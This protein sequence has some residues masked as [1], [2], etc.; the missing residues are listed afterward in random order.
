MQV[1]V[2]HVFHLLARAHS[3]HEILECAK[4]PP[5]LIQ[6]TGYRKGAWH[7]HPGSIPGIRSVGSID[8]TLRVLHVT[9]PTHNEPP[10]I[11]LNTC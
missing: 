3:R 8:V 11:F 1:V 9:C 4:T 2:C 5:N 7:Q 10:K 6:G